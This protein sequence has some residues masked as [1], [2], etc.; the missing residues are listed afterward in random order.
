MPPVAGPELLEESDLLYLDPKKP[1]F[2][3]FLNMASLSKSLNM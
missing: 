1:T 3:G 2:L